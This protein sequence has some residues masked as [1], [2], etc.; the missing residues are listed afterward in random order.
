MGEDRWPKRRRVIYLALVFCA[1]VI[2]FALLGDLDGETRQTAI[3][4]A[5]WAGS[6]IIGSYCFAATWDDK[7]R[8][9]DQ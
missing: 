2:G 9:Q 4:Q 6:A 8:K 5:F 7:G 1:A 3:T